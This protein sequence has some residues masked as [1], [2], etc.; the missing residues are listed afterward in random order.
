MD[1]LTMSSMEVNRMM[2]DKPDSPVQEIVTTGLMYT[3]TEDT[4]WTPQDLTRT[5]RI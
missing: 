5:I 1:K 3:T 4:V 2:L